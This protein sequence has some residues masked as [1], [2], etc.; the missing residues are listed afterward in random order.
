MRHRTIPSPNPFQVNYR[1]GGGRPTPA[2]HSRMGH[3]QTNA[4]ARPPND[5]AM[6]SLDHSMAPR[7][8]S[9]FPSA[10]SST[11]RLGP[12]DNDL[13]IYYA[14]HSAHLR[15]HPDMRQDL[16]GWDLDP[17]AQS[18]ASYLE[19]QRAV[20]DF[21][22]GSGTPPIP[23]EKTSLALNP[24]MHDM[25]LDERTILHGMPSP[26]TL[27]ETAYRQY[28]TQVHDSFSFY[29]ILL[30][31][32]RSDGIITSS[33]DG[34]DLSSG[35]TSSTSS[36]CPSGPSTERETYDY[37]DGAASLSFR[38]RG[39]PSANWHTEWVKLG[40]SP[41][42]NQEASM[43]STEYDATIAHY[44]SPYSGYDKSTMANA[45][46]ANPPGQSTSC[47][48]IGSQ[49]DPICPAPSLPLSTDVYRAHVAERSVYM[50]QDGVQDSALY[51]LLA[52]DTP[53]NLHS[54]GAP[55]VSDPGNRFEGFK[56][57][58]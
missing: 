5:Y 2:Y 8:P 37:E 38:V 42:H 49:V 28:S 46:G 12:R 13:D 57:F 17:L 58:K 7:L 33:E 14:R 36:R 16:K 43:F 27:P 51:D 6:S 11:D 3:S 15:K 24:F 4:Y 53:E 44:S 47:S 35:S 29:K 21:A 41:P 34:P 32:L 23:Q 1:N 56:F 54:Y 9:F 19:R 48:N 30:T 20:H 50:P 52:H 39:Y 22:Y 25:Q 26:M 55:T 10:S 40:L 31:M 45:M 18:Q